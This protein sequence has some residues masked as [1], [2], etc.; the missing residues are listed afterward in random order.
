M[1]KTL[2]INWVIAMTNNLNRRNN[3]KTHLDKRRLEKVPKLKVS[4][5]T[6]KTSKLQDITNPHLVFP[7]TNIS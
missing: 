7:P 2:Q 3:N 6:A 4:V 5:F 1:I